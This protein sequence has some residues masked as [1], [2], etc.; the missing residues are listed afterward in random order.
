MKKITIL[1]KTYGSYKVV[2]LNAFRLTLSNELEGLEVQVQKVYSDPHDWITIELDGEDEDAAYNL[3]RHKYGN[4]CS[5]GELKDNE[6]R[7]GKIIQAGK[8]GYGF[9]IDIGID[10]KQK[11]D[12]FLPLHTLRRQLAKNEKI[13]LRKLIEIYGFLDYFKLQIQIESIDRLRKNVQA[14]LSTGQVDEIKEWAKSK[15]ERLIIN[16]VTRHHLKKVITKS[17]HLR[18]IV[19]IERLGLLEEIIICKQG[20]N[21]RG[22]LTKIG[23]L[24]PNSQIQLFI[25][26]KVRPYIL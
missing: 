13:P 25:P 20:T 23:P 2:A 6:I 3:L 24:L 19:A 9:F 14:S 11:I 5:L 22:I 18:D 7:H 15:L 10:S 4:T 17:G 21:A 12:A 16:G 26:N 1:E 8:Y